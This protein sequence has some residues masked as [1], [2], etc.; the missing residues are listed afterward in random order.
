MQL[1]HRW[2]YVRTSLTWLERSGAVL[3]NIILLV[4]EIEDDDKD[5]LGKLRDHPWHCS[6]LKLRS[7][8][9]EIGRSAV[10]FLGATSNDQLQLLE[11]LDIKLN[12]LRELLDMDER[13]PTISCGT[14]RQ[15]SFVFWPRW[16]HLVSASSTSKPPCKSPSCRT[17]HYS[18]YHPY[19]ILAFY[20]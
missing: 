7:D 17:N 8:S 13:M 15:I 11:R 5:L 2:D 9:Y 6:R 20:R 18:L 10:V 3:L 16:M 19:T 14:M 4:S 1:Y 12:C